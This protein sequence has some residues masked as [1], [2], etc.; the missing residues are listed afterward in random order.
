M[1]PHLGALKNLLQALALTAV[2][3]VVVGQVRELELHL[4]DLPFIPA[5]PCKNTATL[6]RMTPI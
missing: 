1:E 6:E 4:L 5:I 3:V 2:A